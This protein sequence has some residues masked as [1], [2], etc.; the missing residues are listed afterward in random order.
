VADLRHSTMWLT[1]PFGKL[2]T[3]EETGRDGRRVLTADAFPVLQQTTN[4][5]STTSHI[6]SFTGLGCV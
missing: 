1:L 4:L 3:K 6:D 2:W 5:L